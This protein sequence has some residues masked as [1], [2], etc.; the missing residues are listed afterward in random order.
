MTPPRSFI[1]GFAIGCLQFG[2]DPYDTGW[3]MVLGSWS[4]VWVFAMAGVL[5]GP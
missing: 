2:P 1:V 5:W 3:L 4:V